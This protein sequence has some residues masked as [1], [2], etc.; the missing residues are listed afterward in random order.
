MW[1]TRKAKEALAQGPM[2]YFI[3]YGKREK[4]ISVI[5]M[6]VCTILCALAVVFI[7]TVYQQQNGWLDKLLL[8]LWFIVLVLSAY[9]IYL[10]YQLLKFIDQIQVPLEKM[11][12]SGIIKL[13]VKAVKEC[14]FDKTEDDSED[15]T[16][17]T[18]KGE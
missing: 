14:K 17:Q 8:T 5:V 11:G 1:K 3:Y 6:A 4:I 7:P 2:A 9:N 16:D 13:L 18:K 15:K 10:R 12:D